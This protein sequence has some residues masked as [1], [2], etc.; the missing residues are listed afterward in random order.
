MSQGANILGFGGHRALGISGSSGGVGISGRL[1]P[2]LNPIDLVPHPVFP[3]PMPP[4]RRRPRPR[5]RPRPSPP[6]PEEEFWQVPESPS[7]QEGQESWQTTITPSLPEHEIW[8][9]PSQRQGQIG[10]G[11][12]VGPPQRVMP[13]PVVPP[14]GAIPRPH[15]ITTEGGVG[16]GTA[17]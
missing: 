6:S 16:P 3:P 8:Q 4:P 9:I 7:P 10:M 2:H 11:Q 14:Q 12:E 5:P 15:R 1:T 17:L 13:T